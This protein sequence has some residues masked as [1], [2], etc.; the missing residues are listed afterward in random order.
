[1]WV[2]VFRRPLSPDPSATGWRDAMGAPWLAKLISGGML[3]TFLKSHGPSTR[4]TL[5]EADLGEINIQLKEQAKAKGVKAI[6]PMQGNFEDKQNEFESIV[7]PILVK[8]GANQIDKVVQ[9]SSED[10]QKKLESIANTIVMKADGKEPILVKGGGNQIDKAVQTSSE[11]KQMELESI[12]KP[13][14]T[15]DGG[16]EI[17]TAVQAS[18]EDQQKEFES[19]VNP[20]MMKI[21]TAMQANSVDKQMEFEG[22]VKPI[23]T[24][25]GGK[26]IETAVQA[27]SEDQQKEFE[28]IVNPIMMKIETAMRVSSVDKQKELESIVNPTL[29]KVG[30][31]SH[32]RPLVQDM[33]RGVGVVLAR[34]REA[35]VFQNCG[36]HRE[37]RAGVAPTLSAQGLPKLRERARWHCCGIAEPSSAAE[38]SD[39]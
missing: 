37:A 27:S 24:K 22:I 11:D 29:M 18:S 2:R 14:V 6:F 33:D 8:D 13:I 19:I 21:E 16:K 9:T 25:D 15:K 35:A 7:K 26:D 30:V 32:V 5:V 4:N 12:A 3:L 38:E 39:V 23:V 36:A 34:R 17:E 28:S 20:I 1:P 31:Q 10:M